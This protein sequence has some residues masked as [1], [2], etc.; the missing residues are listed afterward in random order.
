MIGSY[1]N[2]FEVE[3]A[4]HKIFFKKPG[5]F[6]L[7]FGLSIADQ[8]ARHQEKLARTA[9]EGSEMLKE[10]DRILLARHV[11]PS[12]L[13][14]ASLDVLQFRG[15]TG[16][17][18]TPP[19][20]KASFNVLKMAREGLPVA[21]RSA[22]NRAKKTQSAVRE[23]NLR[24][25]SNGGFREVGLE[26]VPVQEG[27]FLIVFDEATREPKTKTKTKAKA[28]ESPPPRGE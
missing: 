27:G 26:V 22:I 17:Y 21:L 13:V 15:D 7:T 8:P 20:G 12:V 4:K 14:G 25:R 11:P 10:A 3:D 23:E 2:L 5:T 18:L 9:P 24:V 28:R 6:R 19:A 16:L 1:R